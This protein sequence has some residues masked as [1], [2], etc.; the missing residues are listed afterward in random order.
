MDIFSYFR[1][2]GIDTLDP[3]FYKQIRIWRSWYDSKVRKFHR[4]KVY[5][6]ERCIRELRPVYAWDGEKGL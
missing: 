4:Y 2:K 3:A 1:D 6:G 5:R